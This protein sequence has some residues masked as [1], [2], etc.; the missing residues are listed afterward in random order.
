MLLENETASSKSPVPAKEDEKEGSSEPNGATASP[1]VLSDGLIGPA[2]ASKKPNGS[3]DTV[4]LT[5]ADETALHSHF[6]PVPTHYSSFAKYFYRILSFFLSIIFLSYN[7][8]IALF[9]TVPSL[10]WVLLS[11]LQFKD[12]NRRRPFYELEKSRR[13]SPTGKLKCD[14]GY[15]AKLVGLD[16]EEFNIETEDGF[17]LTVQHIVDQRPGA[18]HWR[19]KRPLTPL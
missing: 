16:T 10:G 19:R 9:H 5:E 14:V 15:Y 18:V 1:A 6:P 17:I 4:K 7:I 3:Q 13:K 12:P 8:I 11:W 2:E